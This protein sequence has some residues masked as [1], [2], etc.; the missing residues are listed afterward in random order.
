[1]MRWL[2]IILLICLSLY[3]CAETLTAERNYKYYGE[4][5]R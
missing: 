4:P 2:I 5:A 1:M 3:S